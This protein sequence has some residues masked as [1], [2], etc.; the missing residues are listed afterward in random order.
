M[1]I[2]SIVGLV[3]VLAMGVLGITFLGDGIFEFN[4]KAKAEAVIDEA[5][6]VERAM[7][8]YALEHDGRV[9]LGDVTAGENLL[10]YLKEEGLL[11]QHVGD[12]PAEEWRLNDSTQILEK[13]VKSEEE[14]KYINNIISGTPL[15]DAVPTCGTAYCCFNP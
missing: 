13:L 11:K 5:R 4:D 3:L 2:K 14:C 8:V 10:K 7:R 6:D 1:I 9:D 15:T 12:V